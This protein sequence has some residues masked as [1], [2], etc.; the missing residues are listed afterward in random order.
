MIVPVAVLILIISSIYKRL[1]RKP[2]TIKGKHVV[3]TG[4]SSGIGKAVAEIAVK[5]GAHVTMVAR[6]II[7]MKRVENYLKEIALSRSQKIN[8]ICL[9]VRDY[10]SVEKFILQIDNDLPIDMLVNCAGMSICGKI[11]DMPIVDTKQMIDVNFYGTYNP[12]KAI[13]PRMKQRKEGYILITASQASFL[14]IFGFAS[15]SA[16]K[17]ALRGLAEA[18]DMEVRV[19]NINVTIAFPPDT[20]TPGYANEN[21]TKLEETKLICESAGLF[22]AEDVAK[23]MLDDALAEKFMSSIGFESYLLTTLCSGMT[24]FSSICDLLFQSCLL[25]L[26]K[27]I[28]ALYLASFNRIIKKVAKKNKTENRKNN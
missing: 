19:H 10:T 25:G 3:I 26:F 28:C 4:G 15:Y 7:K 5:Q 27:I 22:K 11:E 21:L 23:K 12:I 18:L 14:G 1:T 13:L 17:Y 6:N 8:S 2:K 16:S 24:R 20:D 9:D